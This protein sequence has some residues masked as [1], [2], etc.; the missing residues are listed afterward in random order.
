M[1]WSRCM[2]A[3]YPRVRVHLCILVGDMVQ[4]KSC[5][6][7]SSCLHFVVTLKHGFAK[8]FFGVAILNLFRKLQAAT[9]GGEQRRGWRDVIKWYYMSLF[10][11]CFIACYT[12]RGQEEQEDQEKSAD[13][14]SIGGGLK[15][16]EAV[17]PWVTQFQHKRQ[18][19]WFFN[20]ECLEV[21][22]FQ[23]LTGTKYTI[24]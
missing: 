17:L 22:H 6:L 16:V 8:H 3:G 5:Y 24:V 23:F 7:H 18:L 21:R 12:C 9:N 4:P 11:A 15:H 2:C 1:R 20:S 13:P 19:K 14:W 10:S